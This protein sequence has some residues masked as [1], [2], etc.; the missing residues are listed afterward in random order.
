MTP[1]LFVFCTVLNKVVD[2]LFFHLYHIPY[3]LFLYLCVCFYRS[4]V[5]YVF[6][7]CSMCLMMAYCQKFLHHQSNYFFFY[8]CRFVFIS[9]SAFQW[10]RSQFIIKCFK[11]SLDFLMNVIKTYVDIFHIFSCCFDPFSFLFC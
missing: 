1:L 8:I 11:Y 2:I 10:F 3:S 9:S 4:F 5:V 7:I 6:L